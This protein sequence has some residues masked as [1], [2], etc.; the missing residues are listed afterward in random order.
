MSSTVLFNNQAA[1]TLA[2]ARAVVSSQGLSS[3]LIPAS[4]G[5]GIGPSVASAQLNGTTL[6]ITIQH[7]G[8]TD[9]VVPLLASQ[10]VG[11]ALMDGGTIAAPGNIILATACTRVSATALN[12]TLANAPTNSHTSCRLFYPWGGSY[13]S[14][15][16]HTEIGRG[17][18]VTDNYASVA[19]PAGFD[20]NIALGSG[21]APNMPICPPMTLT[22]TGSDAVA[23]YGIALSS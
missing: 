9:L 18:A 8:G 21:W 12:V 7:D 6:T 17:C 5:A 22:G 14:V 13:S 1:S 19:K 3:T 20:I 2:A 23:E 15:Q 10:G 11:W 16:P 4:L